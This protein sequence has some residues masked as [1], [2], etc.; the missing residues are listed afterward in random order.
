MTQWE[1]W[2]FAVQSLAGQGAEKLKDTLAK[3]GKDGWELVS[4]ADGW[5]MLLFFFK[6]PLK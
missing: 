4:V 1:Y 2:S 6:R 3:A 5:G